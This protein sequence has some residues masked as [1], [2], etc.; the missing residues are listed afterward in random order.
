MIKKPTPP[1]STKMM[2]YKAAAT[3]TSSL[4]K[5]TTTD[6]SKFRHQTHE[7]YMKMMENAEFKK[8]ANSQMNEI[9]ERFINYKEGR[10]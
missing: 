6:N 10:A 5:S 1:A 9:V 3:A 7:E 4:K 8:R 2:N